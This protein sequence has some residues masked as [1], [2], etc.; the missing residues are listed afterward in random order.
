MRKTC[1]KACTKILK[2]NITSRELTSICKL[3]SLYI[4]QRLYETKPAKCNKDLMKI[5]KNIM[6]L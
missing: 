5:L 3:L 2:G 1:T 6:S 4:S